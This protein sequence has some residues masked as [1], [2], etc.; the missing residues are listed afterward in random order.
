MARFKSEDTETVAEDLDLDEEH[1]RSVVG[2][3]K[4]DVGIYVGTYQV[5]AMLAESASLLD[6]TVKKRGSK[7]TLREGLT[8][9]GLDHE[10]NYTGDKV[11]A[12]PYKDKADGMSSR[13]GNISG[14]S[15]SRSIV[16]LSEY[17]EDLTLKFEAR[18]LENRMMEATDGK[19]LSTQD[20]K[21]I[22]AHARHLGL[23]G[24]RKYNSGTFDVVKFETLESLDDDV[25]I[26]F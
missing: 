25:M 5:K 22:L 15:G 12:L 10:D 1:E 11:Y 26:D 13:T 6:I 7:Q 3:K 21:K 19:K 16:S 23:G 9:L 4:T 2:F 18:V 8:I 20:L 24:E 14:P 17:V